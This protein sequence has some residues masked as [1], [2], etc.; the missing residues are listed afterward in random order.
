MWKKPKNKKKVLAPTTQRL[1]N[2]REAEWDK[3]NERE[4]ESF[5]KMQEGLK[6]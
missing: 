6:K 1:R 2:L 4:K 3:M 5:C